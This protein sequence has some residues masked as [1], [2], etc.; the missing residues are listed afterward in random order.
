MILLLF[1]NLALRFF[2]R[3]AMVGSLRHSQSRWCVVDIVNTIQ[4]L[5]VQCLRL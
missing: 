1:A 5:V 4:P 3:G 2:V